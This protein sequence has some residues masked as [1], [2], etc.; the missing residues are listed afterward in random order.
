VHLAERG[1]LVRD[2]LQTLLAKYDV[3]RFGLEG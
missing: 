2:E 1:E 3:E